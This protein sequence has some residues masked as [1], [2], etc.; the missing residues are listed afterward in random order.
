MAL[1]AFSRNPPPI[2]VVESQIAPYVIGA[3]E[4]LAGLAPRELRDGFNNSYEKVKKSW[5]DIKRSR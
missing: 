1:T 4:V 2:A 3:S 5:K